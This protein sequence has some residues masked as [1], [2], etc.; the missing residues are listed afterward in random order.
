MIDAF[1]NMIGDRTHA[2]SRELREACQVLSWLMECEEVSEALHEQANLKT[3]VRPLN[4]L[5]NRDYD[6]I[7]ALLGALYIMLDES[8][9]SGPM[10]L[11][12]EMELKNVE[13]V[14]HEG[15]DDMNRLL[16]AFLIMGPN[17]E[18]WCDPT[19][20]ATSASAATASIDARFA[21][22]RTFTFPRIEPL[23]RRLEGPG[24]SGKL[25]FYESIVVM[26]KVEDSSNE[27]TPE[28]LRKEAS[29]WIGSVTAKDVDIVERMDVV[30]GESAEKTGERVEKVRV[31]RIIQDLVLGVQ[32]KGGTSLLPGRKEVLDG[33]SGD[34]SLGLLPIER[35]AKLYAESV[36]NFHANLP[37][38]IAVG[39]IIKRRIALFGPKEG[40]GTLPV[41]DTS[42]V[43]GRLIADPFNAPDDSETYNLLKSISGIED[44]VTYTPIW[45]TEFLYQVNK[46]LVEELQKARD[47]AKKAYSTPG[48]ASVP[49]SSPTPDETDPMETE[50]AW[51]VDRENTSDKDMGKALSAAY[52]AVS[53]KTV[54][55][56]QKNLVSGWKLENGVLPFSPTRDDGEWENFLKTKVSNHTDNLTLEFMHDQ[57]T[58]PNVRHAAETHGG[59]EAS[60][61]DD[62]YVLYALCRGIVG[63]RGPHELGLSG[64]ALVYSFP[65]SPLRVNTTRLNEIHE[66]QK[67]LNMDG[68]VQVGLRAEELSLRSQSTRM[69]ERDVLAD[70]VDTI[71]IA[72]APIAYEAQ[73]RLGLDATHPLKDKFESDMKSGHEPAMQACWAPI[74][75]LGSP[76]ADYSATG[77]ALSKACTQ[78]C[79][80]NLFSRMIALGKGD[81]GEDA[82]TKA[83][84]ATFRAMRASTKLRQLESFAVLA[85]Q[86]S[87]TIPPMLC[88]KDDMTYVTRPPV[89]C[90]DDEKDV[91]L[92]P[93]N[94][95]L[96]LFKR[97]KGETAYAFEG[98]S[99]TSM[100]EVEVATCG[101]DET[102]PQLT[103]HLRNVL[104]I[105]DNSPELCIV[106]P[107]VNSPYIKASKRAENNFAR[108]GSVDP[109]TIKPER[110]MCV[111]RHGMG[112]IK[113]LESLK[114]EQNLLERM[115]DEGSEERKK[116]FGLDEGSST[117]DLA[118]RDRR[119]TMWESAL[120]EV[121]VS[122]DRLLIFVKTLSGFLGEAPDGI[123]VAGDPELIE[124][125]KRTEKRQKDVAARAMQ[126]QSSVVSA[127]VT[128][129]L[130]Q[131]NLGIGFDAT[132][133]DA[134]HQKLVVVDNA[135]RDTLKSLA[136][137]TSGRPFFEASV[138][139]QQLAEGKSPNASVANVLKQLDEVGKEFH[140]FLSNEFVVGG[141]LPR[142]SPETLGA[143][144]NCYLVRLK[145]DAYTA[146]RR[147]YQMLVREC[148]HGH[149]H[150]LYRIPSLWE[151]VEGR[152]S[153]LVTTFANLCADTL[154]NIRM[155]ST[156]L[157]AYVGDTQS[158]NNR[159]Q[160][161]L[162]LHRMVRVVCEYVVAYEPPNFL[163]KSG[164]RERYFG[165]RRK[166]VDGKDTDENELL[167]AKRQA[168]L[169][170]TNDTDE[171]NTEDDSSSSD[172]GKTK[173]KMPEP[174]KRERNLVTSHLLKLRERRKKMKP[175]LELVPG[176]GG[177]VQSI[178]MS[179]GE[180]GPTKEM[181][182]A[183]LKV[184]TDSVTDEQNRGLLHRLLGRALAMF[185]GVVQADK[186]EPSDEPVEIAYHGNALKIKIA[187]MLEKDYKLKRHDIDG[188]V[189]WYMD[190]PLP[191]KD[192][193]LEVELKRFDDDEKDDDVSHMLNNIFNLSDPSDG[194]GIGAKWVHDKDR[195]NVWVRAFN[196]A[197][198]ADDVRAQNLFNLLLSYASSITRAAKQNPLKTIALV[199]AIIIGGGIATGA[200]TTADIAASFASV[201]TAASTAAADKWSWV[202]KTFK[203]KTTVESR[204]ILRL[205]FDT[206]VTAGVGGVTA[207]FK[208]AG[209]AASGAAG[210]AS[211]AASAFFS[212]WRPA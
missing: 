35:L 155:T 86:K 142:A 73:R 18:K 194:D 129:A 176:A 186:G 10:A 98:T 126:M 144:H 93:V 75:S 174:T 106:P 87:G 41:E 211:G 82:S 12:R 43:R 167:C 60:D 121:A 205:I 124:A 195:P 127:V 154:Q 46:R 175:K 2:A 58:K 85:D 17:P 57:L 140:R 210:Y 209:Y 8:N 77:V 92:L 132:G 50:P 113:K 1:E 136:D 76:R 128:A 19:R 90:K 34:K 94:S 179:A 40:G 111:V 202:V 25:S 190:L 123:V 158:R 97:N 48:G 137:G 51:C 16:S 39:W 107:P 9:E 11:S 163:G 55:K 173:F 21:D 72:A 191:N 31:A 95:G 139:L 164:A 109:E 112:A 59:C 69:Y 208:V 78:E 134:A 184:A 65:R 159:I 23:E 5:E 29:E 52:N 62:K 182:A 53:Q 36:N 189:R 131:S 165:G 150:V 172:D 84:V 187:K 20:F 122:T 6:S 180:V 196:D 103:Q 101:D 146:I 32:R 71:D 135:A 141:L 130:K 47:D 117:V 7:K 61:G 108:L 149:H 89:A 27:Y 197:D 200:W 171:T 168:T 206:F 64:D 66:T 105:D 170:L 181:M 79:L 161:K 42:D 102:T 198:V 88:A 114:R 115:K 81:H 160:L 133:R 192:S 91:L 3:P 74:P 148:E 169:C 178:P 152:D 125:Q 188:R 99:M 204:G 56:G 68:T 14:S 44:N 100:T 203:D 63:L 119:S 67:S 118:S 120:R 207:P 33:L 22:L 38:I 13:R 24:G 83:Q 70:N 26:I 143:P 151:C 80:I 162:T 147:A 116:L 138:S 157:A 166:R 201:S 37:E 45:D 96:T 199:V 110:I 185:T 4:A 54:G 145:P 30:A 193:D 212:W 177:M 15:R 49:P 153:Q 183:T 156:A 104:R 28:A